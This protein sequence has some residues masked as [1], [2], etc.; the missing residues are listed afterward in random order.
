MRT[1]T[2]FCSA[3]ERRAAAS[4]FWNAPVSFCT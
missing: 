4:I 2:R 3:C 1:E